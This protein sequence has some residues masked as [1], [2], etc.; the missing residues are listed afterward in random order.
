MT[1]I[2]CLTGKK[3]AQAIA[4]LTKKGNSYP[5]KLLNPIFKKSMV[6]PLNSS[7]SA[8]KDSTRKIPQ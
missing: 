3:I 7:L 1:P 4:Q 6:R 2:L 8:I 5:Q